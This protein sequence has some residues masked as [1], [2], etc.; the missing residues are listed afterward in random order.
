MFLVQRSV[1]EDMPCTAAGITRQV[2]YRD[3]PDAKWQILFVPYPVPHRHRRGPQTKLIQPSERVRGGPGGMARSNQK[4]SK[5]NRFQVIR[6]KMSCTCFA[7]ST[8]TRREQPSVAC[9]PSTAM[10]WRSM[11]GPV[12]VPLEPEASS[13][14]GLSA[15]SGARDC[16][17]VMRVG[18]DALTGFAAIA[19]GLNRVLCRLEAGGAGRGVATK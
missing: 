2:R 6:S 17:V 11:I 1:S 19:H 4:V 12:I 16:G 5:I 8:S 3:W 18:R 14:G 10:T 9:P 13:K 15:G 7:I